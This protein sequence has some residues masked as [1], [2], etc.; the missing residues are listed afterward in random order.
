MALEALFSF[1][2]FEGQV[3]DQIKVIE[4]DYQFSQDIDE[5]GKPSSRPKGGQINL[6][7][8]STEKNLIAE[9]MFAKLGYKN[10]KIIFPMRNGKKKE[11]VFEDAVCISYYEHFNTSDNM[12]MTL[13]F[14]ISANTIKLGD[15]VFTNNWKK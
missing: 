13:H 4:C 11:L 2:S 14:S 12:P 10:G 3:T 15:Q 6:I 7:V 8:E 5:M 1:T 9:W